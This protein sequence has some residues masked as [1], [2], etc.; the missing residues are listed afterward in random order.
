MRIDSPGRAR[1]R[2]LWVALLAVAVVT[3]AAFVASRLRPMG[4]S[5][6][7]EA[8]GGCYACHGVDEAPSGVHAQMPCESCHLGD[9][10]GT[11]VLSAHRGLEREP[12]AL[13]TAEQTCGSCHV[14]ELE[15]VRSSMMATGRGLIAVNRWALGERPTPNGDETFA[16]LLAEDTPT[17]A[18]DHTRRLCAGCHLGTRRDNRDDAIVGRGSG[19]AACHSQPRVGETHSGLGGPVASEACFGCHSR[20]TRISLSYQGL[21]EASGD[22]AHDCV[23]VRQLEDGRNLCAAPADRHF[24]AGLDC[25]DCH[26]H[27]ELMGDGV[28]RP[29]QEQAVELRCASCHGGDATLETTWSAVSDPITDRLLRLYDEPR[30]ASERV[31]TGVRGTPIYNL[32]P[33]A[34]GQWVLRRKSGASRPIVVQQMRSANHD[35]PGHEQLACVACHAAWAPRCP[36]CH[37][38]YVADEAQWDFGRGRVAPGRFREVSD[39]VGAGPPAL[40]VRNDGL[41]MPAIPGMVGTLDLRAA[42]GERVSLRLYSLV[43]PHTTGARARSCDDCHRQPW[44]LGLGS[45]RFEADGDTQRFIADPPPESGLTIAPSAWTEVGADRPGV[46]TRVGARSLNADELERAMRVGACLACHSG[47]QPL[48]RDFAAARRRLERGDVPACA[49]NKEPAT[50]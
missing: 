42:G 17:P 36:T 26:L 49:L 46:G 14:E 9:P 44:A 25:V 28:S 31:R 35:L 8:S 30:P 6:A 45:G 24:E 12:G 15:H 13:D 48:Y 40:G 32:R 16:E 7:S 19:C 33:T 38:D 47:E 1:A 43:D 3:S 27:T 22:L 34:E 10:S 23:P 39:G 37:T 2:R 21:L 18:Q 4:E 5:R 50:L 29:H 41:I 20:S 11:N